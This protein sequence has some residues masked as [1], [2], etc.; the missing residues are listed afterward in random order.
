MSNEQILSEL[1]GRKYTINVETRGNT[2]YVSL[3]SSTAIEGYTLP[4]N[5]SLEFSDY[6]IQLDCVSEMLNWSGLRVIE[7]LNY[8]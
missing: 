6:E 7:T 1:R 5:Y 4:R 8:R 3:N 2:K